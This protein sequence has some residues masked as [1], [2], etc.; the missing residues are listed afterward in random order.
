M[1]DDVQKRV[2]QHAQEDLK[3][4]GPEVATEPN[5]S[6]WEKAKDW[7]IDKFAPEVGD[8]LMHKAAQGAAEISQ[9][10]NSQSNAYVPYGV[11][12]APLEVEGPAMS[13]QDILREASQRV[14][15]K[16]DREMER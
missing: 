8:M 2:I 7:F 5:R 6:W 12:Q 13:Y 10:L 15:P 16:Q 14:G 4:V 11:G 1:A 9:A 3:A